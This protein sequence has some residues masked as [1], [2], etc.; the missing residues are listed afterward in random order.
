MEELVSAVDYKLFNRILSDKHHVL[1]QLLSPDVQ[2]M[3][4]RTLSNKQISAGLMN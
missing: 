3:E 1:N 4:T 2:T